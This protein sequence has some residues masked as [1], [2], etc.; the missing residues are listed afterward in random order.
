MANFAIGRYVPYNSFL[1]RLD[2]RSKVAMTIFLMIAVFMDYPTWSMRA[3]VGGVIFLFLLILLYISKMKISSIL[4]S[5]KSMWFMIIFLLLIYILVPKAN[6]TLGIA[7][8]INDFVVYWDSFAE[9]FRIIMR[10]VM[11][12]MITMILTA[13]TRPLDLTFALEWYL[14]PLRIVHFPVSEIA[15]ML[16]IALRFIPTLLDDADRIMKAQASRGVDFKHGKI[17]E[18]ILGITSLIIPLFVSSFVRS[19]ELA[20]AMECRGYDPREK[21]SRYR[22]YKFYIGDVISIIFVAVFV[23]GVMSISILNFDVFAYFGIAAL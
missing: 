10:L 7:F 2:A 21:R 19:D 15:M 17:K 4:S 8:K 23:A 20:S 3:L 14:Y 16:S 13:T 9:A 6:N 22:Q 12:I 18:K 1:H 5:L 11:M